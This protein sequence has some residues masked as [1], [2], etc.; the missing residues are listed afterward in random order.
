[1]KKVQHETVN[2]MQYYNSATLNS[3]IFEATTLKSDT[4][5]VQKE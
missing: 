3:A 4:S 5:L 2:I 1:M